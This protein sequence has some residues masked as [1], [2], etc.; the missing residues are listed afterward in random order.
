MNE[1]KIPHITALCVHNAIGVHPPPFIVLPSLQHLPEELRE[2]VENG[3]AW[4]CSSQ[5]GWMTR[6]LFFLFTIHFINWLS[7]YRTTL[8][9]NIRHSRALLVLDAHTSRENPLALLLLR[10]AKVDVLTIPGHSSH[11]TQM[12]DVVLASPLKS[13]YTKILNKLLKIKNVERGTA[14]YISKARYLAVSA[15]ISAWDSVCT[16]YNCAKAAE[17]CGYQP[18]NEIA[19]ANSVYVETF[20]AEREAAYQERI[21]RRTRLDINSKVITEPENL[22]DIANMISESAHLSHMIP[23]EIPLSYS[24]I[25]MLNVK[26][27]MPNKTF[28]LGR[29]PPFINSEGKVTYFVAPND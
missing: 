26:R 15:F 5:S 3:T 24:E 14:S 13:T 18:F 12:F 20:S 19:I 1:F 27:C 28:F 17:K 4:F 16:M 2:F 11:V 9:A 22:Q 7:Q 25:I 8:Q 6:D 10:N 21:S 23:S 29:L